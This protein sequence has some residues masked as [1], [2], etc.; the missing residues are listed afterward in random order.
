[1]IQRIQTIYLSISVILT[2]LMFYIKLVTFTAP[3]G[4]FTMYYNGIFKGELNSGEIYI[5]VTAFTILLMVSVL[6]GIITIFLYK[7]RIL[8]IRIA[9]LNIGLQIGLAALIYFFAHT[10]GEELN[11]DFI[12]PYSIALPVIS[13][14]LLIMAIK[15]IGKDEALIRSMD[16]IR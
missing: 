16:R 2:S 4:I 12:F 13:I 9:G 7:N 5:N 8:Q 15:A 14:I 3:D 11:A 1:M 10:V 6:T